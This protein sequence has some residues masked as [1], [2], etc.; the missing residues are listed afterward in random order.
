MSSKLIEKEQDEKT[1][2]KK[3]VIRQV[4]EKCSD[5][6][7]EDWK[8]ESEDD[9]LDLKTNEHTLFSDFIKFQKRC[10]ALKLHKINQ[11]MIRIHMQLF[12]RARIKETKPMTIEM[13]KAACNCLIMFSNELHKTIG[14][15]MAH[16]EFPKLVSLFSIARF[17]S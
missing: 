8:S 12:L 15:G 16:A 9:F 11:E 17:S 13:E 3:K 6:N 2:N 7:E 10:W 1:S 4:I 14:D 5:I